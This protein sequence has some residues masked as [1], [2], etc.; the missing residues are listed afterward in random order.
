MKAFEEYAKLNN[1]KQ[2]TKEYDKAKADF[3]S[4]YFYALG[5]TDI[6][7]VKLLLTSQTYHE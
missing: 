3:L 5:I 6:E 4:G 7:T 1:L 2:G